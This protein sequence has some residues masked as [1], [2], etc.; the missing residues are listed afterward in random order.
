MFETNKAHRLKELPILSFFVHT[1][2]GNSGTREFIYTCVWIIAINNK[3]L[4]Q[5]K[6]NY[7]YNTST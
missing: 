1:E 3:S 7:E 2:V 5:Y 6:N 4:I